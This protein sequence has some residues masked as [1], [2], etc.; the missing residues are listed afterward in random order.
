MKLKT[1]GVIIATREIDIDGNRKVLVTIGTPREF[2]EGGNYFCPYQ[3][4][5]MGNGRVRY[6][7][8]ADSV[9]ALELALQVIGTDLYTSAEFKADRLRS[10]GRRNLGF[11]VPA[12][13]SDLVP[14]D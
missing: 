1:V 14:K 9:Q 2:P 5:G 3:I 7:G 8:G 12:T 4:S 13:I 11:P 6:A 10:E